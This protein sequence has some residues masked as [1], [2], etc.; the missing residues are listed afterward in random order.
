M[1]VIFKSE[2]ITYKFD[3]RDYSTDEVTFTIINS[4][5]GEPI[6]IISTEYNDDIKIPL[7]ELSDIANEI[8]ERY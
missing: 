6:I 3:G 4:D 5:E 1:K 8:E 2:Q 7:R